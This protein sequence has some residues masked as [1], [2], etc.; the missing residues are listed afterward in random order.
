MQLP[1]MEVLVTLPYWGNLFW[2]AYLLQAER[3]WIDP[4]MH[5]EKQS[6]VN[7]TYVLTGN[8]P[9]RLTVPLRQRGRSRTPVVALQIAEEHGWRHRHARTILTAYRN[10][11]YYSWF[12]DWIHRVYRRA[13][14]CLWEFNREIF[15]FCLDV[16]NYSGSISY[17]DRFIPRVGEEA[18]CSDS[19]VDLRYS[20]LFL[21]CPRP[22]L[23]DDLPSY[24][25]LFPPDSGTFWANLSILDGLFMLGEA[26]PEYLNRLFPFVE[27]DVHSH[28]GDLRKG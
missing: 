12:A 14:V 5:F 17:T 11:P 22:F 25:Q 18:T 19:I 9:Y 7:R 24:W 6:C 28:R 3:I 15:L 13:R 23:A 1:G 2:W 16:L 21:P 8:G 20:G 26:L 4:W 27:K 10:A